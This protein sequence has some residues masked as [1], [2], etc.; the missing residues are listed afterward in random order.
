MKK[1]HLIKKLLKSDLIDFID[2]KDLNLIYKIK[3]I[4][5]RL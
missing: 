2:N 4:K 1:L 3:N 5:Y